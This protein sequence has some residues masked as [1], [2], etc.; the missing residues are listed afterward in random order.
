LQDGQVVAEVDG[1]GHRSILSELSF[2]YQQIMML[3]Q[4]FDNGRGEPG[5]W[6]KHRRGKG[7]CVNPRSPIFHP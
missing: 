1:V 6:L 7:D 3:C 4:E 5:N 2:I